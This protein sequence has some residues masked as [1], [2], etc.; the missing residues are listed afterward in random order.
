VFPQK[1]I[2]TV[3]SFKELQQV[4]K[5]GHDKLEWSNAD[6]K[7]IKDGAEKCFADA[8]FVFLDFSNNSNQLTSMVVVDAQTDLSA[9]NVIDTYRED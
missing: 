1:F 7:K 8:D 9:K 4:I 5:N 6:F 2:V 3:K